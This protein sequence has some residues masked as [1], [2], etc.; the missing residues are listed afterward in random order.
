MLK[1][2]QLKF[3]NPFEYQLIFGGKPPNQYKEEK[4]W[5][6]LMQSKGKKKWSRHI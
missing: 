2:G 1:L 5:I 6:L 3:S 4:Q